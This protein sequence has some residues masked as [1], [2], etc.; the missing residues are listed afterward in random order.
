MRRL[1]SALAVTSCLLTGLPAISLAQSM[2]GFTIFGGP[3]RANQLNYR[4]DYGKAGMSGDR[5]RLRIPSQ[6]SKFGDRPTEHILS[7][8][9]QR[10]IRPK[11]H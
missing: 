10:R 9:L 7:R 4:L 1:F 6:K 2:P 11:R 3:D 8:L 5:Y